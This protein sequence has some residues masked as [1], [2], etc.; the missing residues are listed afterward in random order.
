MQK[1][2]DFFFKHK[3]RSGIILVVILILIF[4]ATKIFGSNKSQPQY[5]TATVQK[6]TLISSVDESG[7]VSV[8]NRI[9]VT[10]SA[11]G[12]VSNILVKS[13][14]QV[15]AGQTIATISLDNA[16]QQRQASAYAAYLSAQNNLNSAKAQM[17][18]LQATLFQ[19]NQAFVTDAGQ[20]NPDT[21][22]PKYIEENATWLQA[23]ANYTNQQGVINSAQANLN[24]SY[25]TY[26][27]TS[28]TIV[29]P[30]SGTISD[31]TI[32]Q[33][34]QIG[35]NLTSGSS[36]GNSPT[37]NQVASIITSGSPIIAVNLTETDVASVQA[38]DKATVTLDAFPNQTFTGKIIGIDT[39]GA[40]SSGVTTYPATIVLDLPNNKILPNMSA[41]ANII[42]GIKNNVLMVPTAAIQTTNGQSSV[43]VLNNGQITNVSITIGA[44]SST[45]TEVTSGNLKPD[46]TVVIGFISTSTGSSSGTS[47]FS[48]S[49]FGGFGGGAGGAVRV[50]GG[51]AGGARGGGGGG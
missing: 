31:L 26:Q 42:T 46:D 15:T 12:I 41:S 4:I 30:T 1:F 33:G 36:S 32:A 43:R 34:M 35:S 38:G 13:G 19:A 47:P 29:A 39:T 28:S 49:I 9:A 20:P 25:L 27:N 44:T 23:Q 3:I 22:D 40:V 24:N 6:G 8:A 51:G 10:T 45:D 50:G 48:R 14:Q 16:G 37:A 17:N 11:S 5:Q 18:S 7:S 21:S 2:R